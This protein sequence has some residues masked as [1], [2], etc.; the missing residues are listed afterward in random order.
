MPR[1]KLWLVNRVSGSLHLTRGS[2]VAKWDFDRTVRVNWTLNEWPPLNF[3]RSSWK[4]ALT[5]WHI[6]SRHLPRGDRWLARAIYEAYSAWHVSK[7]TR[8]ITCLVHMAPV[9]M[10]QPLIGLY[11]C[12]CRYVLTRGRHVA[13]FD[14]TVLTARST[15]IVLLIR[16]SRGLLRMKW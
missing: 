4:L 12:W 3:G 16:Q 6:L 9:A 8:V 1:V 14:S 10:C 2:C 13:D 11:N 7:W 5:M 15:R